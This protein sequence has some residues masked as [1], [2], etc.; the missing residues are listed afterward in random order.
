[1]S[2]VTAEERIEWSTRLAQ[3]L[4]QDGYDTEANLAPLVAEGA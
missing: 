2:P 4:V 3:A 1:M